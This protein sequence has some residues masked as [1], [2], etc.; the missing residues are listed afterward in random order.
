MQAYL[1]VNSRLARSYAGT[2]TAHDIAGT[3]TSDDIEGPIR[4]LIHGDWPSGR[5]W[6]WFVA[7]EAV[8]LADPA[9]CIRRLERSTETARAARSPFILALAEVGLL[10]AALHA[11]DHPTALHLFPEAIRG[12]QRTGSW[13]QQWTTSEQGPG[14]R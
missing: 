3:A 2:A 10:A 13:F 8:R 11:G 5:A 1:E 12:W 4:R 6:R 9:E 7:A 14:R